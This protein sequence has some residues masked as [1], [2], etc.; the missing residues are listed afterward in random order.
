MV[1]NEFFK[2]TWGKLIIL[3]VLF[4]LLFF[5]QTLFATQG[6]AFASLVFAVIS[7]PFVFAENFLQISGGLLRSV[8]NLIFGILDFI[9]WYF[10]SCILVGISSL[11]KRKPNINQN[12]EAMKT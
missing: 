10:L 5:I 7:Q 9:Y 2:P 12:I 6:I 8:I 3:F 1:S 11:G 4:P